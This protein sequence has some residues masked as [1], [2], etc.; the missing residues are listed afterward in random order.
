MSCDLMASSQQKM[1]R[2]DDEG[3]GEISLF[4]VLAVAMDWAT[5]RGIDFDA[6]LA[7]VRASFDEDVR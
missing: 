1:A 3:S 5:S 6:T 2:I 7:E 4:H